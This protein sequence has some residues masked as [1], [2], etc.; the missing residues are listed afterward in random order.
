MAEPASK[1]T[2]R[3]VEWTCCQGCDHP[4]CGDILQA[5]SALEQ[6]EKALL[7]AQ[8]EASHG[9]TAN[10]EFIDRKV[11]EALAALGEHG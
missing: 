10:P 1:L 4:K 3:L 5:A 8:A 6:A 2:D 9:N 7:D 11:R